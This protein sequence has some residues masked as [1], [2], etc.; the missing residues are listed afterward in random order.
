MS[1]LVGAAMMAGGAG[2][3]WLSWLMSQRRLAPGSWWG[4]RTARTRNSDEDWYT[5]HQE[6]A[7][8]LGVAGGI[9]I[10]GGLAVIVV[11][12]D[13]RVGPLAIALSLGGAGAASV[14]SAGRARGAAPD[15]PSV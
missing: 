10:L 9:V 1:V 6:A 11:G 2:M 8:G 15:D 4:I 7:S 3:V 13:D 5:A 12:L 14:W